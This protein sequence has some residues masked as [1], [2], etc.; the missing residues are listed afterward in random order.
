MGQS[1]EQRP[2]Q[3][4][5]SERLGPLVEGKIRGDENRGALVALRDE[6]EQ[7]LRSGL[8]QRDE[9]QLVNDQQLVVGELFLQPQQ[10]SFIARLHELMHNWQYPLNRPLPSIRQLSS[11]LDVSTTTVLLAYEAL[12]Q[13][14]FVEADPERSSFLMALGVRCRRAVRGSA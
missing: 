4:L 3:A 1:V 2:G 6:L 12:K 7:Q 14:G 13:D 10:P 5:G 8:R 11:E 9:A